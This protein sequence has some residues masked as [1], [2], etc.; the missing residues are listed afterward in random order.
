MRK[1]VITLTILVFKEMSLFFIKF[2]TMEA[3]K[4][5][6]TVNS[7]STSDWTLNENV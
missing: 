4:I 1:Q 7:R 5:C 2:I 3:F 6:V